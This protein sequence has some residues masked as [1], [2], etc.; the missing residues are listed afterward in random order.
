MVPERQSV[1][2]RERCRGLPEESITRGDTP[3]GGLRRE[4][5]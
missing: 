3:G 4:E 5:L 1:G 2:G